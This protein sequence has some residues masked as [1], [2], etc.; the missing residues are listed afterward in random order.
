M[1]E[2]SESL[3]FDV[4]VFHK[5]GKIVITH[6]ATIMPPEND[7]QKLGGTHIKA[8]LTFKSKENNIIDILNDAIIIRGI[9]LFQPSSALAPS[10]IGRSGKT[11]GAS[12]VKTHE[13][14]AIKISIIIFNLI[15]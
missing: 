1:F 4:T 9:L 13:R 5:F 6:K 10:T 7:F 8:V 15:K 2:L 3:N 14:K 11:H 12:T